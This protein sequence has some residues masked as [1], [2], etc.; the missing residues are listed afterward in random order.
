MYILGHNSVVHKE[1]GSVILFWLIE[2]ELKTEIQDD[3]SYP[4][5]R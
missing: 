1:K 3:C 2:P 5:V 4:L